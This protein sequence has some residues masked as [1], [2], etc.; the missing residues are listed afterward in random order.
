MKYLER[1]NVTST[2]LAEA[3]FVLS[4]P[5]GIPGPSPVRH[6]PSGA[7]KF[8]EEATAKNRA[9][10]VRVISIADSDDEGFV[11]LSIEPESG[12]GG[13]MSIAPIEQPALSS[14]LDDDFEGSDK[15]LEAA[16]QARDEGEKNSLDLGTG[17]AT[18]QLLEGRH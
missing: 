3:G 1:Y 2:D 10:A 15:A 9:P 14:V 18:L 11:E 12:V 7:A 13:L 4:H 6:V 16:R 17:E 5:L 8:F